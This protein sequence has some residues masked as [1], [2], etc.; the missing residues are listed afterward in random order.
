[1]FTD[2]ICWS[3]ILS[4]DKIPTCLNLNC[5]VSSQEW[6]VKKGLHCSQ[7]R[8]EENKERMTSQTEGR[9]RKRMIKYI[10]KIAKKLYLL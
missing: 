6:I 1:M 7:M 5:T 8:R 10:E 3:N 9:V 2:K 4:Y